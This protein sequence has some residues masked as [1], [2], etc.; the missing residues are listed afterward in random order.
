M[1]PK[2]GGGGITWVVKQDRLFDALFREKIYL[3]GILAQLPNE[4]SRLLKKLE[5]N[6]LVPDDALVQME[7]HLQQI[8]TSTKIWQ[9]L[10]HAL[11]LLHA[12]ITEPTSNI[13]N[14]CEENSRP[15]TPQ[16]PCGKLP[17]SPTKGHCLDDS[18]LTPAWS[19][20]NSG[21][22]GWLGYKDLDVNFIAKFGAA[23]KSIGNHVNGLELVVRRAIL[24]KADDDPHERPF[25]QYFLAE[26]KSYMTN[27]PD[28][29]SIEPITCL[30]SCLQSVLKLKPNDLYA[31]EFATEA[32]FRIANIWTDGIELETLESLLTEDP[33]STLTPWAERVKNR[34]EEVNSWGNILNMN[35]ESFEDWIRDT[36]KISL[37]L[38]EA[39]RD[40]FDVVTNSNDVIAK[41]IVAGMVS[42]L[43]FN[44][45][46]LD[47]IYHRCFDQD[48]EP[49]F[50]GLGY[51]ID[52]LIPD[53]NNQDD[54][55]GFRDEW[56]NLRSV[57]LAMIA[58]HIFHQI[59]PTI[60]RIRVIVQEV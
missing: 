31:K 38:S 2:N 32:L 40:I 5:Q 17:N 27:S 6:V 58:W 57:T 16:Q 26:A 8:N 41:W 9:N 7:G 21:E 52:R 1:A 24:Q 3:D 42:M 15:A 37:P 13:I 53:S 46:T 47:L 54:E 50:A 12:A 43:R 4:M 20:G 59:T 14:C 19:L 51:T 33:E 34:L 39:N 49:P 55:V 44:T 10:Y 36:H 45:K 22:E 48:K 35:D 23:F 60:N 25:L 11:V 18:Y 28:M 30:K 56:K 29:T